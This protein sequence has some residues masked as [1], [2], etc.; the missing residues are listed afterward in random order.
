MAIRASLAPYDMAKFFQCSD[1]ERA[2]DRLAKLNLHLLTHTNERP[3]K[4]LYKGCECTFN[5]KQ[6]LKTHELSHT[7]NPKPFRCTHCR[8]G[9][10]TDS[11]RKRHENKLHGIQPAISIEQDEMECELC[12]IVLKR[13][14]M[15]QSQ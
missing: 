4:C 13:R 5:R 10:A 11:S 2:F 1:C 12:G 9:F 8:K 7:D 14:S 15:C 6:Y 3:F